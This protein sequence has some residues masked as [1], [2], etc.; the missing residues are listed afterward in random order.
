MLW[1]L[2]V[3]ILLFWNGIQYVYN[4]TYVYNFAALVEIAEI[5]DNAVA[6]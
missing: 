4:T 5:K 6:V 1:N 2:N 3:E